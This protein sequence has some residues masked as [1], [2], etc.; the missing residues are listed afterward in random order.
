MFCIASILIKK[1]SFEHLCDAAISARWKDRK[2]PDLIPEYKINYTELVNAIKRPKLSEP[3]FQKVESEKHRWGKL[4]INDVNFFLEN[5]I[6]S[7]LLFNFEIHLQEKSYNR[8]LFS[9]NN[10]SY[11]PYLR[12]RL[13]FLLNPRVDLHTPKIVIIQFHTSS[14]WKTAC[15]TIFIQI[16]KI[17]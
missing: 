6:S 5:K 8:V 14:V 17:I 16:Q 15:H 13:A 11:K 4:L 9:I 12:F 3:K 1:N 7:Q 10:F 2:A